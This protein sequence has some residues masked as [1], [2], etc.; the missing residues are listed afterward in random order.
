MRE[1]KHLPCGVIVNRIV[2]AINKFKKTNK[3]KYKIHQKW[4]QKNIYNSWMKGPVL[5]TKS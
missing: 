2:L 4:Q 1:N 3:K 5:Q